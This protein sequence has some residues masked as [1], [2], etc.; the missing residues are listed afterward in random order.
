MP[1]DRNLAALCDIRD[2]ILLAVEWAGDHSA[3]TLAEDVKTLFAIV[4]CLGIISEA[5]RRL[6]DDVRSRN[7]GQ[8]WRNIMGSGNIYR[9]DY[10]DVASRFVF[11]TVRDHLPGLLAVVEAEIGSLAGG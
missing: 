10:D 4:R 11:A 5:A 9:H 3:E 8:P 6:G 2:S 7:P 1:S